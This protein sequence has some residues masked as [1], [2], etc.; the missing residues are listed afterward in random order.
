MNNR[1]KKMAGINKGDDGKGEVNSD[2][3]SIYTNLEYLYKLFY[4]VGGGNGNVHKVNQ[5][6]SYKKDIEWRLN[7]ISKYINK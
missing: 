5:F 4:S 1:I 6:N 2:I 7:R 3:T